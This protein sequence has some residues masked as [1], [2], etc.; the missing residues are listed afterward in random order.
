MRPRSASHLDDPATIIVACAT[1]RDRREL[2]RLARQHRF[3]WHDYASDALEDIVASR[4]RGRII[5]AD[6]EAEIE[7]LI[8]RARATNA[9]AIISTDDYPG[10]TLAAAVAAR[11]D[12]PGTLPHVNLLC[13][14]K[15]HARLAQRRI[16]PAAVPRFELVAD[17]NAL[18]TPCFVK[19]VKSFFSVGAVSV[20]HE[21]ALH[22]AAA[23]FLPAAFHDPF[24]RLLRALSSLEPTPERAIAEGVLRGVQ[25]TVEG[26][27]WRGGIHILGIVDSIMFP[28][29][30]AFRRFE[31]PSSLPEDVQ[32]RMTRLV[33]RL[34]RGLG[35]SHGSFNVELMYDAEADTIHIIE[36]NP[37][38]S[39]QFADLFEK[40]RGVNAYAIALDLALGRQPRIPRRGRYRCAVSSVLRTFDD[41]YVERV[42]SVAEVAR[43]EESDPDIRVEVLAD[44]GRLLSEQMQDSCS[45]RYG[46]VNAGGASREAAIAR[47]G[48]IE[49]ELRFT[50]AAGAASTGQRRRM[51][52]QPRSH[53]CSAAYE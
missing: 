27:A 35:Y 12:W 24:N 25:V 42:P 8:G 9:T 49:R 51:A 11:L 40:I 43:L 1:H 20:P 39:S 45:Y 19:P 16:A 14:H 30:I 23:A 18:R 37:R 22:R 7:R 46:I 3:V 6:P 2:P 44:A 29:T 17:V 28:G 53:R 47:A 48:R 4:P 33:R 34:M 26:F 32:R 15:Y 31:L 36:V 13:Q 52:G 38:L 50:L 21:R 41:A 5:P 10:S